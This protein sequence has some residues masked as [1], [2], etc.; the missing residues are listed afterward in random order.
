MHKVLVATKCEGIC[1]F[2][3]PFALPRNKKLSARKDAEMESVKACEIDENSYLLNIQRSSS[4]RLS[5][6][7][8]VPTVR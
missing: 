3:T 5:T 7:Y 1:L 4:L 6:S 8:F 2:A